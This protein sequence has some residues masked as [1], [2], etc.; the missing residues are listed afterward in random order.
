MFRGPSDGGARFG[1]RINLFIST[2]T[3]SSGKMKAGLGHS[4]MLSW[5]TRSVAQ[6][7][8][9]VARVRKD[10][11]QPML[12]CSDLRI[13]VSYIQLLKLHHP[14]LLPFLMIQIVSQ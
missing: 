10:R 13:L 7:G 1:N 8:L 9:Q 3:D 4:T 5:L 14:S 11:G 2:N 12:L 6:T